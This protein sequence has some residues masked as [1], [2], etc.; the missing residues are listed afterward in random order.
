M[1]Q[2]VAITPSCLLVPRCS[3]VCEVLLLLQPGC[4]RSA[5]VLLLV[6]LLL[7][8][9]TD[10]RAAGSFVTRPDNK[11]SRLLKSL[12]REMPK[13]RHGRPGLGRAGTGKSLADRHF[14]YHYNSTT[15][16]VRIPTLLPF[17]T[18][19]LFITTMKVEVTYRPSTP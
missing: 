1:S 15:S 14:P 4:R 8:T 16:T 11:V 5:P 12:L 3:S 7:L 19:R 17:C 9:P 6:R 18:A 13:V 2:T 10:A